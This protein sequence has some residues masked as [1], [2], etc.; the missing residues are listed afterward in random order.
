MTDEIVKT[1]TQ[2]IRSRLPGSIHEIILFGSRA[3]GDN[4]PNSD[5]DFLVIVNKKSQKLYDI[6][7]EIE[8]MVLNKFD[9][10]SG[11]IICEKEEWEK[12]KK[13]P[14]GRNIEREGVLV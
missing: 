12:N 9:L 2:S 1:F 10:L 3:R 8:I 11:S 13:F 14:V 4:G 5:Y 6:I 7:R